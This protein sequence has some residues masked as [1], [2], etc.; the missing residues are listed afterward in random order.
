MTYANKV[1]RSLLQNVFPEHTNEQSLVLAC[2]S[3][4]L[5]FQR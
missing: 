4:R 1:D 2:G 5:R 3:Y